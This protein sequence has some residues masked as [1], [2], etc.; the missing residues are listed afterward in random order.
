MKTRALFA[1][2]ALVSGAACSADDAGDPAARRLPGGR[3]PYAYQPAPPLENT[4]L[5]GTYVREITIAQAGGPPVSCRR[6]APYRTDAGRDEL[7]LDRGRFFVSYEPIDESKR[8]PEC[9]GIPGFRVD[10]HFR[11]TGDRVVFYNDANCTRTF[12]SYRWALSGETLRLEPIRDDC[13]F[14]GLRARFFAA[15]PWELR[16]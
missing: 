4:P 13:A 3:E 11:V 7:L 8:C 9:S 15:Y 10:G 12:G 14:G 6:C 16:G 5:D 2:L 1:L